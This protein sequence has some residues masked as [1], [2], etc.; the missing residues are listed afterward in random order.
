MA[1]MVRHPEGGAFYDAFGG[2]IG[3]VEEVWA[4]DSFNRDAL[5]CCYTTA[6]GELAIDSSITAKAI[7]HADG[8]ATLCSGANVLGYNDNDWLTTDKATIGTIDIKVDKSTFTDAIANL[9]AQIDAL[10]AAPKA[11]NKLRPAL[12][13]LQYKREVE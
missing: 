4:G 12:K 9:Q 11:T 2:K 6:A 5:N 13:T 7:A 1:K 8:T 10:K 3:T